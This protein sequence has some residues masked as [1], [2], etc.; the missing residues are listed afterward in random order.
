MACSA[1]KGFVIDVGASTPGKTLFDDG[2]R[3]EVCVVKSELPSDD[4]SESG[5]YELI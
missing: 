4:G 2:D 3:R 5:K 1:W